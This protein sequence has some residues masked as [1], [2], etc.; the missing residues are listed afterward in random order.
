MDC[1]EEVAV[2]KDVVGPIV[3]GAGHLSFDILNGRMTVAAE[4]AADDR[5]VKSA[6]AKTGMQAERWNDHTDDE[7]A[8]DGR[9]LRTILTSSAARSRSAALSRMPWLAGSVG[10]ALGS[11]RRPRA[12]RATGMSH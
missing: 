2:L 8:G 4:A 9:R 6:V 11:R 5:Q 10:A 12:R 1:A 3:G 7:P